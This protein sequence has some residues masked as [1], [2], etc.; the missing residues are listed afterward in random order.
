MNAFIYKPAARQVD[1]IS[2]EQNPKMTMDA[3]Q[4]SKI[5]MD[6][7]RR[8]ARQTSKITKDA[9][10]TSKMTMRAGLPKITIAASEG[11]AVAMAPAWKKEAGVPT[12]GKAKVLCHD[13]ACTLGEENH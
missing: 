10:Q 7:G 5:T 12:V 6:G 13:R 2:L 3:R 4:A 1:K 8:V 11:R 9:H